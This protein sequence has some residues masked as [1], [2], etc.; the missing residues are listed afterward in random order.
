MV[1]LHKNL[2]KLKALD[3]DVDT[4]IISSDS[5]EEQEMLY[6]EIERVLGESLPIISDPDLNMIDHMGMKN[7]QVAHRGY[8]LLDENG[9]VVFQTKNDH[10]GEEIEQTL[11]EIKEEYQN[12][13]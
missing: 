1:Q 10:W 11:S 5:P 12:M 9:N 7:G 3:L 2:D 8:G 13:K 6:N 4:Y